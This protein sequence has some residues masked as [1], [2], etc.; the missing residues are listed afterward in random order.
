MRQMAEDLPALWHA[1]T[2][3][4]VD[5][6]RLVRL[7]ISEVVLTVDASQRCAGARI[8]WSGG[9]TTGH[10]VC[11]PPVGWAN[12]TEAK[13]VGRLRQM[14]RTLPDP[15]NAERANAEGGGTP[16]GQGW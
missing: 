1:E 6:K 10:K 2:T 15:Q 5:R 9:A 13:L 14:A 8:V 7:V 16:D 4:A 11:L 12:R 3:T